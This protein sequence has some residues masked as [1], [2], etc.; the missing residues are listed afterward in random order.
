MRKFVNKG[1]S[2]RSFR[3]QLKTTK[4]ANVARPQRGGYRL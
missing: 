4:G 3:K 2:A 1:K